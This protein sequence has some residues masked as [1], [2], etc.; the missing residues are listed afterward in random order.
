LY[1]EK[2]VNLYNFS[3]DGFEHYGTWKSLSIALQ[4]QLNI[5]VSSVSL[6][7]FYRGKSKSLK[8]GIKTIIKFS[9]Q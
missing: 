9:S 4:E 6:S 3:V 8:C 1:G 2:S 5:K 7:D